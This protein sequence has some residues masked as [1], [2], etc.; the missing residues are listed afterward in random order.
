M[1]KKDII[2]VGIGEIAEMALDYFTYDSIYN[3]VAFSAEQKYINNN[4]LLGIP[5]IAFEKLE[6]KFP[7]S[8]YEAFVAIGYDKL[9]RGRRKLYLD[10]K[11]KGFSLVS[12]ISSKAFVGSNVKIGENCFI[13]EHNVLQRNVRIGNNVTLWSGNHIGHRS[14]IHENC[15][16][17]SHIVISGYCN[18]GENSFIG[19]NSCTVD[20][21]TVGKDCLIGAGA[22]I[23][24][25]TEPGKV[26]RGNPGQPAHISSYN[27]YGIKAEV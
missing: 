14:V 12:Y 24:S 7:P 25:D 19:V 20:N 21:I 13:L 5:V 2:I 18:I 9:N 1:K 11:A 26:Y 15:F 8:S 27:V 10:C 17:S 22:V 23:L 6:E 4:I 3:V 16:F